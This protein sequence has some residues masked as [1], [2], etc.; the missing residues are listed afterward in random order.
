MSTEKLLHSNSFLVDSCKL[1]RHLVHVRITS[2]TVSTHT[3]ILVLLPYTMAQIMAARATAL[4]DVKA[5]GPRSLTSRSAV[6]HSQHIGPYIVSFAAFL[7]CNMKFVAEAWQRGYG[8]VHFPA[9][10]IFLH[11]WAGLAEARAK[12]RDRSSGLGAC[13]GIVEPFKHLFL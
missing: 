13:T 5:L 2:C 1:W 3:Y 9:Q 12:R 10:Y 8:S 11:S 6:R 7:D 4:R